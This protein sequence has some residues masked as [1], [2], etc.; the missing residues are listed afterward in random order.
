MSLYFSSL[1][2]VSFPAV[3]FI[4]S[5]LRIAI[6]LFLIFHAIQM[7][8][9]SIRQLWEGFQRFNDCLVAIHEV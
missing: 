2:L 6:G 5:S 8:G 1:L 4:S 9:H 7:L 3:V